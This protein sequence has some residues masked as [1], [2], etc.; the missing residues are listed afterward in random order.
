MH[1]TLWLI[2][3]LPGGADF[4]AEP[5]RLD[6]APDTLPPEVQHWLHKR[7]HQAED[8]APSKA[9]PSVQE[10][11]PQE[12]EVDIEIA[13]MEAELATL[14]PQSSPGV[15]ALPSSHRFCS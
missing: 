10:S 9:T 11:E 2:W 7:S 12:E 13:R 15:H 14:G 1:C 6:P 4:P 3:P 8:K 5:S